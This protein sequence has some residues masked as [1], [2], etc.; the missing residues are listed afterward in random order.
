MSV[1]D[2]PTVLETLRL[3]TTGQVKFVKDWKASTA[4]RVATWMKSVPQNLKQDLQLQRQLE[5]ESNI[6][7]YVGYVYK[8]SR[9]HENSNQSGPKNLR[10][11]ILI[12]GPR[13]VPPGLLDARKRDS[14]TVPASALYIRPLNVVH[15]FYYDNL[16]QCPQCNSQDVG[17]DG[18]TGAGSRDVH[19]IRFEEKA[20]GYQLR[21]NSC[22][23]KYGK[24]GS[25]FGTRNEQGEKLGYSFATTNTKFW[26][27]RE[28][29]EIPRGVPYFFYRCSLT[30]ELFDLITEVR[31]ST[32]SGKLSENIKQLHLLEYRQRHLEY[33][34]AFKARLTPSLGPDH[35]PLEAFSA[36]YDGTGYNMKSITD[37]LITDVF[38]EFCSRTR[39]EECGRY[40]RTLEAICLNL[41][42]TFKAASKATVVDPAKAH[43]KLMKGGILSVLN[44]LNQIISWRFCQ[45]GSTT[46]IVELLEGLKTRL[47]LLGV[48]QPEM[49]TVD[50][51]CHVKNQILGVFPHIKVLLDVYH[52]MM[53]YLLYA[54][55]I[56]RGINNAHR[57]EVLKNIRDAVI[58]VP[59]TK[60]A[61]AEYWPQQDQELRLKAAFDKWAVRGDVW[62]AAAQNVHVSQMQHVAKGCLSRPRN[63]IAS[64]GSRIEGSHK[65]WNS[66]QRSFASGLELQTALGHDYVL[67]RNIRVAFNGKIKSDDPFILSTFGSHHLALVDRVADTWNQFF[68]TSAGGS[69]STLLPRLK[70]VQSGERFGL[71]NSPHS[72]TFGGLYTIKPEPDD[73]L[74]EAVKDDLAPE[75]QQDLIHELNLNLDPA[76][77]FEPM[78]RP[79]EDGKRSEKDS[80]ASLTVVDSELAV[81]VESVLPHGIKR[82]DRTGS[83]TVSDAL[84]QEGHGGDPSPEPNLKKLR[85]DPP[86]A[87]LYPIFAPQPFSTTA[88][89]APPMNTV[90]SLSELNQ[91]LL[92]PIQQ[93]SL[94]KLT[95]S[96]QLF[97]T[98][99]GIDPRA[100]KIEQGAEFFLLMDMRKEFQWKSFEM[101][102]RRWAEAAAVYNDRLQ[103]AAGGSGHVTIRK[104]P[105]ALLDKM[106]EIEPKIIQRIADSNY[107]SAKGS[108]SFWSG[109][110]NAVSFI[111]IEPNSIDSTS[112]S[113]EP[114]ARKHQTCTR[115]LTIKYPGPSGS[116]EN[117]K[118]N[119]CSDGFKPKLAGDVVAP[120]PLPIGIF[121]NGTDFHPFAFL[122]HVRE[123][124]E[125]LVTDGTEP[126]NLSLE[127]DALLKLL[128]SRI[129]VDSATGAV[130]FKLFTAF[131]IPV[132]DGVPDDLT[133]DYNGSTHLYINSL[134]DSDT[135][136]ISS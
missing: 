5:W 41:D 98:S 82:K 72:D 96:Q 25:D 127:H 36:P 114:K 74:L 44:E 88:S 117:H 51:C 97:A 130:M 22:K 83:I 58:K 62:S 116:A 124:Y 94:P 121:T 30:R 118:K 110:C 67:R 103:K 47:D 77:F 122:M 91:P 16:A 113:S 35:T 20:I 136:L 15:P 24:N 46:E 92:R 9:H 131:A 120:W 69:S 12:L 135:E 33:L 42:N 73:A 84:T 65:G 37:D 31:P 119:Y 104:H 29:W 100:L 95:R 63:D 40:L 125:R 107:K 134:R 59:S 27:R 34:N 14:T 70:D 1:F 85:V 4:A 105:R 39:I 21:C 90:I 106:G 101:T 18:W 28:H 87:Q 45:S 2:P 56:I 43:T 123:V 76:L 80:G 86:A 32:T 112:T 7:E 26:S 17:W 38:L 52:F 8:E 99:T 49:V 115:C 64:D 126:A 50:N 128:Q 54:A 78:P 79:V 10:K 102:P 11:G 108:M 129:I 6:L 60:D 53:R 81:G 57:S 48:N 66:L 111:K 19:G 133:I 71:V 61:P 55:V 3:S 89:P 109:H 132:A 68:P 13:F 23:D 93:A 75:E